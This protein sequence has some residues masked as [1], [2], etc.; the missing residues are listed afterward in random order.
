M[1]AVNSEYPSSRPDSPGPATTV[2]NDSIPHP[3]RRSILSLCLEVPRSSSPFPSPSSSFLPPPIPGNHEFAIR[4]LS[5]CHPTSKATSLAGMDESK[6]STTNGSGNLSGKE[7]SVAVEPDR[8]S[9]APLE[10]FK[11]TSSISLDPMPLA[12]QPSHTTTPL[13]TPP[14]T[15]KPSVSDVITP[16]STAPV[17]LGSATPIPSPIKIPSPLPS[18]SL[19]TNNPLTPNRPAPPSPAASR[20]VSSMSTFSTRSPAPSTST[21]V[22]RASSVRRSS[23]LSATTSAYMPA[24]SAA[25]VVV[26]V[27]NSK[28]RVL[29]RI[30]DFAFDET[31]ERFR[32]AGA[33]VPRANHLAVLHRKLAGLPEDGDE[34]TSGS[35]ADGEDFDV[36]WDKLQVGWSMNGW[37]KSSPMADGPSQE[38]IN[39]NFGGAREEAYDDYEEDG[40][41]AEEEV[42]Y[43]GL[44]R[45][46]YAFEPEGTAEMALVEDQVV[47]VIG[48]GG[49]G[50]WAVVIDESAGLNAD[51]GPRHALVPES[52]LEAVRLDWEDEEEAT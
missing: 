17:P 25:A 3:E 39:L 4:P 36:A 43:P 16:P 6:I 47:R 37:G 48:R 34:E 33:L 21:N 42:L 15:L 50:G 9:E 32:G 28:P 18:P 51:G 11:D 23:R 35:E 2:S 29:I 44:Y 38:E 31:D 30:R 24:Q 5:S 10:T 7:M 41:Q 26:H 46:V 1:T 40:V 14:C 12:H 45:A 19:V 8:R 27:Q 49:G 20:R 22:S 52:Y 13:P